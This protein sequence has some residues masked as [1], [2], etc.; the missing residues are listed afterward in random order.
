MASTVPTNLSLPVERLAG[1]GARRAQLLRQLGIATVEDLFYHFPIR[2][3]DRSRIIPLRDV[4][5]GQQGTYWGVVREVQELRPRPK[6]SILKA[7][8]DDGTGQ[9]YAVWFNQT[10]L[11]RLLTA[12]TKLTVYGR[13]VARPMEKTIVVGDFEIVPPAE[14]V[15]VGQ[16]ILPV[17]PLTKGLTQR[18]IRQLVQQAL[19]KYAGEMPDILPDRIREFYRLTG[20]AEALR[21]IHC[22]KSISAAERGRKTIAYEELLLWQLGLLRDKAVAGQEEGIAHTQSGP[23]VR[24]FL[25]HL[26]FSLTRAQQRVMEEIF[27]DMEQPVPM[28]R[29]LQGDVGSGKTVV[30]VLALLKAIDNGYQG[31]LMVPTEILAEQHYLNFKHYMGSLG[32]KIALA[33]SSLVREEKEK[34]KHGL[35]AGEI[36]LVVGTHALIQEDIAF[37]DLGLVVIDEQHRFGVAQRGKLLAKGQKKPDLLIMT[38]TPIPRTL[39]LT[40]YGDLDFSVI[41]ELPPGRQPVV[42]R[43]VPEK[44]REQAYAFIRQQLERGKQAYIVCPLIDE[45]EKISAEAATTLYEELRRGAF[46]RYRLGLVHGR[47]PGPQKEQVMD[48]FRRGELDVLVATTVIEVGVDVSNATVILIT[49]CERFGL[50]QLHQLRGR[51]GRGRD[52]SYCL[53][54]GNLA[55][56]EA[57]SRV[58]AMLQYADGF[59][60]AEE[61]LKLR[62]P[63]DFFGVRQHGMPQ[64]KAA[65][66]LR[67]HRIMQLAQR[68]A[69]HIVSHKHKAE[70]RQLLAFV[71]EH[72]R[73]FL[74]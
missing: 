68:D 74:P 40:F 41:D 42:T 13:G 48:G 61:D 52:Q 62:G 26:P 73:E 56:K 25:A 37:A 60:L 12:G 49:G 54:M 38:A 36:Q 70:Y 66:L 43:Y 9:A 10:Y 63:G 64:F 1:V 71:Q 28:S 44:K 21:Q 58:K 22:P 34:L 2:Y 8:L 18:F 24:K 39:A 32:I 31:A 15:E 50:A 72:Y 45:S 3:E 35:A 4:A 46:H 59:A 47:M 19:D 29:L 51:V 20:K 53:L 11:K 7:L 27:H 55:G 16:G 14:E 57:K 23:L 17:Y 65:D 6:L 69:R 5:G 30:A 67:D 33:T